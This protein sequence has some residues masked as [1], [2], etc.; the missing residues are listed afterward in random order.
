F[1]EGDRGLIIIDPLT[2]PE[3]ARA[4][5]ELCCRPRPRRTVHT[6][7]YSHS[8]ADHYGGV[9]G[10]IDEADVAAGRV[11]VIA[12][13]GFMQAAVSENVLAGSPMR[14]RAQFQ[15]GNTLAP[16]PRS[17]V[18]SGLGKG[19]GRG[20]VTLIPPTQTI[21]ESIER[22]T[23][24]GIDIVFQS[25][26]ESE[27]PAEMHFFFPALRALNLA[28]N[29]TR[30]MHNLCPLRGA[31]ARDALAW[32]KYLD[33]ALEKFVPGADVVF[34]QHH[35]PVWGTAKVA[36]YVAEQRDLYRYLH[37]QTLRMMGHGMT[38]REIADALMMPSPLASRWHGRGYY[39]AVGH[40][41]KAIYQRYLGWYDGN[42]STLNGL[43]PEPAGRRY[44]EYM[45]GADAVVERARADFE[46]GEFR[47]VA[48]VLN[49]VVFA[50][51][52]HRPARE[53][54][55]DAME[56]LGYQTE[57]STW[58]NAYLLG[59]RELRQGVQKIPRIGPGVLNANV[60]SVLPMEMFFDYLAVRL[61]GLKTQQAHARFDWVLPDLGE[62]HRLELVNGV[63]NHRP[64]S[65]GAQADAVITV[66]RSA[67]TAILM[68]GGDL[69]AAVGDGRIAVSGDVGAVD[70]W[71]AALDDFDPNFNVIEP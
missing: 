2:F 8:H 67:L 60:V 30:T 22:H 31:Q 49:H 59:A 33:V 3:A 53:L 54:A 18:D 51:P 68:T 42:P 69:R 55:A 1:I 25:T 29:A 19:I 12:P 41:V 47:W 71:L 23:I 37:D 11:R 39:G 21:A 27:A 6:V 28:E 13:A 62:T 35:W 26:P 58:R 20:T 56:Q 7:I 43:P 40:N 46:R 48:E 52:D 4:A 34:A 38:P 17:H 10:I 24:D 64:G 9:K 5:L 44:V 61:D 70:G 50:Q 57:S 65:H 36:R 14:R 16:G 32:S 15:F 66:A 45:G 63:L